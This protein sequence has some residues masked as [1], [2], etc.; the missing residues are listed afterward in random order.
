MGGY[1]SKLNQSIA[2]RKSQKFRGL[3]INVPIAFLTHQQIYIYT[4]TVFAVVGLCKLFLDI[5]LKTSYSAMD[6]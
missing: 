1:T 4:P 5:I 6:W 2:L 3:L